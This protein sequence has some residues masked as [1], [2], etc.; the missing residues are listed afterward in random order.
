MSSSS[1]PKIAVIGGAGALGAALSRRWAKA[2]ADVV[3][4]SRSPQKA[5]DAADA[6]GGGVG[7]TIGHGSNAE[8][9]GQD[10]R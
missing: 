7:C 2:G 6:L 8:A 10:R 5:R 9:A 1:A 3:I 4:G